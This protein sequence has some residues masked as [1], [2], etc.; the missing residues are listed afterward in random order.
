MKKQIIFNIVY[1]SVYSFHWDY[2]CWKVLKLVF[3]QKEIIKCQI[4]L[5]LTRTYIY[6]TEG[7]KV[8]G[9]KI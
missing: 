8:N 2:N 1:E 9:S 4:L 6:I 5:P 7:E 3:L